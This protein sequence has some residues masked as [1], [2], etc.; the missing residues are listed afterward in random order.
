M[1]T[2]ARLWTPLH[3]LGWLP[4]SQAFSLVLSLVGFAVLSR[5][6]GSASYAQFAVLVFVYTLSSLATDLSAQ[7]YVL[8][9]GSSQW[10]RRAANRSALL[11]GVAGAILLALVLLFLNR[12]PLPLGPPTIVEMLLLL[13]S[14]VFQSAVQPVRGSLLVQRHYG[15]AA[16]SDIISTAA[17]FA[18]SV[19]LAL[20]VHSP[21]VLCAQLAIVSVIR[22]MVA[23]A[24]LVRSM[25]ESFEE[26]FGRSTNDQGPI[27]FGLRVLPLNVA[28]YASRSIDSGILPFILSPAAAASYARSYQL[29]VTP[30]TQVQLSLGG[31]I[32]ERLA[33]HARSSLSATADLPKRIWRVLSLT[34]FGSGLLLSVAAPA[35][36]DIF[37]GPGWFHVRVT[38][39]AMACILPAMTLSA[40]IGWQLQVAGD[41]RSALVNLTVLM[42]VPFLAILGGV[43]FAQDGAL[44]GL[45]LGALV[46]GIALA[47]AHRVLLPEGLK[48]SLIQIIVE[49]LVLFF[50]FA[51]ALIP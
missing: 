28:S 41:V 33:T 22:Y 34:T 4:L 3:R 30:I 44:V 21:V 14:L 12:L 27:A 7:G 18:G 16:S 45:V 11:S 26:D 47:I 37:F 39:A 23:R 49:W 8:V 6:L 1:T 35:I 38:I 31:V 46:Q 17:G 24:V 48:R 42:L 19:A 43:L 10:T 13:V 50:L 15:R 29:I 5:L 40:F 51:Y 2:F 36:Q 20:H 32:V 9:H 25:R